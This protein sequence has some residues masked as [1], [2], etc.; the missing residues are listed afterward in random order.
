[1]L[2][3]QKLICKN[4]TYTKKENIKIKKIF[5]FILIAIMLAG[6]NGLL[7]TGTVSQPEGKVVVDNKNYTMMVG[8][9]QWKEDNIEMNSKSSPDVNAL[10]DD[11]K[12]LEVKKGKTVKLEIEKDPSSIMVTKFKEDGTSD[13][14]DI[15]NNK[16]I[17]PSEGGYYI[18]ELQT[19]WDQGKETFVFDVNVK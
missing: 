7:P 18:Y 12:T 11:F 5:L 8:N 14:V 15:K 4:I 6:C 2:Y 13:R 9:F 3:Y 1:M 19:T 16:I 17:M 10:A